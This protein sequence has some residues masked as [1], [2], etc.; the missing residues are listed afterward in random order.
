MHLNIPISLSL[1]VLSVNAH[2]AAWHKGMY[3]LNGPQSTEDLNA[4][5]VVHPLYQL[6]KSDW[7]FHHV[8]KCDEYP[9]AAGDFLELPA[10]KSF[11]VEIASN[12]A[13]T[14]LSYNGQDTSE[15]PDGADYPE[16]RNI[17]TCITSPN[18]HTQ[19]ETMAAGTA[20]AI[21]Y[22]SD[23]TKVTPEN[24]VVFSVRL[25]T[26]WKRLTSYD[27]P[28]ALP[29]CPDGG[30]ICAWG[31]VPNGCGEPNMYQH[32]FK[33]KVTG[34]TGTRA[35]GTPKPPVWCEDNPSKCVTG[36]KQMI[37]WNQLN[38][39][40]IET[41]GYDLSGAP[42]SP[43]YNGK[44]GFKDGVQDDIF[45]GAGTTVSTVTS[46]VPGASSAV[47]TK[48]S[49]SITATST[50]ISGNTTTTTT[51]TTKQCSAKRRRRSLRSVQSKRHHSHHRRSTA[52]W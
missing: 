33:C 17:P 41:D 51:T 40:N 26:P 18:M 52:S 15:W 16:N 27:V 19:N 6:D 48:T 45:T 13:K 42:R 44:L 22:T 32:P 36:P 39:N 43:A 47:P 14:S 46:K 34:A 8:D 5:S 9:P 30:C 49:T 1:L 23:I 12:R 38:G 20:F 24:L 37:Y 29:E 25:H 35:V 10:G 31:W 28:A 4:D 7:W 11:T 3:C 2:L 50:P 21:S